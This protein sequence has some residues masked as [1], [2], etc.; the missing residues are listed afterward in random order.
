MGVVNGLA[1]L[2]GLSM[3][4]SLQNKLHTSASA[5]FQF[6]SQIDLAALN[7]NRGRDH[8]YPSYTAFRTFCGFP[9]VETFDDL[10]N[11]PKAN[12][13]KLKSVYSSV[14]DID[15]W[16]GGL[17]E[18]PVVNKGQIDDTFRPNKAAVGPTFACLLDKQFVELK[19]GDRFFYENKA[20][21]ASG[22][23]STAFTTSNLEF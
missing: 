7:I 9:S 21:D 23:N 10:K 1:S 4:D 14:S 3:A 20:N 2:T 15:L 5:N 18:A 8:G 12:I 16:I 17:A 13:A 11:I 22:T 6:N 19:K